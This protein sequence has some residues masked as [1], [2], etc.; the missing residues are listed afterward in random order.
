MKIMPLDLAFPQARLLLAPAVTQ[1]FAAY[2]ADDP[3]DIA[4]VSQGRALG[5]KELGVFGL[6]RATLYAADGQVSPMC[7]SSTQPAARMADV[8]PE[9]EVSRTAPSPADPTLPAGRLVSVLER[10]DPLASRQTRPDTPAISGLRRD[11]PLGRTS[12]VRAELA[13]GKSTKLHADEPDPAAV[14]A[15]EARYQAAINRQPGSVIVTTAPDG[16]IQ[17][18]AA[19]PNLTLRDALALRRL[20]SRMAAEHGLTLSGL[21]LNGANPPFNRRTSDRSS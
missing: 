6:G 18:I 21:S 8:D 15:F 9:P 3:V 12:S 19:A 5:F 2:L 14:S 7:A 17:I 16:S 11:A 10:P 4:Q 20:A 1:P 13:L